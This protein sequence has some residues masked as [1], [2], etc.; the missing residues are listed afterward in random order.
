MTQLRVFPKPEKT[1]YIA[2]SLHDNNLLQ[3]VAFACDEM[4]WSGE[5]WV[6]DDNSIKKFESQPTIV[7]REK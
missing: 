5:I 6:V 4:G 2:P 3:A 1:F 7:V